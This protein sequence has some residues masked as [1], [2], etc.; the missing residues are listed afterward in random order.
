MTSWTPAIPSG[1]APRYLAIAEAIGRDVKSGRLPAGTR[2]PTHRDLAGTLGVTVG[3]ITRAYGEAA[4]R[5]LLSGEVG[6]G[7]FVRASREE[8]TFAIPAERGAVEL[9]LSLNF[10]VSDVHT[11]ALSEALAA[12]AQQGD[13]A[14]LFD[15]HA[16]VGA[17]RHRAAG[18][19]WIRRTGLPAREEDVLV[20]GGAQ[21]AMAVLFASIAR[22]GDT[23]LT[24]E[25]T[26][27]GMKAV[28]SLLHLRLQGVPM[29]GSGLR[30]DAFESACRAAS[31]RA[32]YCMPTIHNPTCAVMPES[33]RK[34]IASIARQRGVTIV[35]D[36]IYG[37]LAAK[38]PKPLAAFAPE[39]SY[40]LTS[41]S[42]SI[43]P[44]L[45]IG[46]LL[47]PRGAAGRLASP[48]WTLGFMA[49]PLMAEITARW[50]ADGTAEKFVRWRRK[51]A[52]LR[53]KIARRILG[54]F[55]S[56]AH[57]SSYH[58]WLRLPEPWRSEELVAQAKR[59]GVAITPSTA[60]VVGR[61]AE[62]H[63][64][65]ISLGGPRDHASLERA[66]FILKEI[67]DGAPEPGPTIV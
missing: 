17:A 24:E 64:A 29:D 34:E 49:V 9:D 41:A 35:E 40:Y 46:Y 65:R 27:P 61:G 10:P 18:A 48:L 42:K 25:L 50:I 11:E 57:P 21:H 56:A 53:Q 63:A 1:D 23:V 55:D 62:P 20:C 67:L 60:F 19:A 31:P 4:R 59:R 45:R 38:P 58:L 43:L 7:T 39:I 8:V 51:E 22:P 2:L 6:R 37:F 15:Y 12:A 30:P 47:A 3:T 44:G 13:L 26:Y 52:A 28:A 16:H 36:D 33:R 32:L 66:L 5:G 14:S 54:G